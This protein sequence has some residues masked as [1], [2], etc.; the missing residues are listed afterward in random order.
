[1]AQRRLSRLWP[2]LGQAE[3]SMA[4]TPSGEDGD[5]PVGHPSSAE[6]LQSLSNPSHSSLAPGWTSARLSLQSSPPVCWSQWPSLS[7]SEQL[8]ERPCGPPP[9]EPSDDAVE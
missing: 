3:Q 8:G 5:A 4:I 1:M 9:V 6:P 2:W 7:W